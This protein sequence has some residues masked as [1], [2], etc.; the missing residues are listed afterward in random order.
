MD[1]FDD[2][3]DNNNNIH[4]E[5]SGMPENEE[6]DFGDDS[7]I[8][9]ESGFDSSEKDAVLNQISQTFGVT[10]EQLDYAMKEFSNL[11][12][13]GT[14][15][16]FIKQIKPHMHPVEDDESGFQLDIMGLKIILDKFLEGNHVPKQQSTNP[17]AGIDPTNPQSMISEFM[18]TLGVSQQDAND[19]IKRIEKITKKNTKNIV[20]NSEIGEKE[21]EIDNLLSDSY[22][23]EIITQED[24]FGFIKHTAS[25]DIYENFKDVYGEGSYDLSMFA[26]LQ[27]YN[28][29]PALQSID[30][31]EYLEHNDNYILLR[32]YS[33]SNNEIEDFVV[34]IIQMDDEFQMMVPMYGNTYN[35]ESGNVIVKGIDD[36]LYLEE[37]KNDVVEV[38]L[39]NPLDLERLKTSID[40]ALYEEKRPL[41]SVQEFGKI[42]V[43]PAPSTFTS[44][45]VKV[46]RIK[47][48]DSKEVEMFKMHCDIDEDQEI[49]D[50]YIKLDD[51]YSARMLR[52][53]QEYFKYIDFNTN[54]KIKNCELYSRNYEAL[55]IELDLGS[56]PEFAHL[57]RER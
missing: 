12:I 38:N 11:L 25:E 57:W 13:T 40:I 36:T 22:E 23:Y 2:E 53:V 19:L 45:F 4:A 48:Y 35:I 31:L 34:A 5:I 15:P 26:T 42:F 46:G 29:A 18:S 56:L 7:N 8:N 50:F 52:A 49:F 1:L 27:G 30:K 9:A 14:D 33:D 10:Q 17:F 20:S 54:E 39:K 55:Y 16:E 44:N 43:A 51:E 24:S 21:E 3:K 41:L 6:I 32:A 28:L 47:A 37:E